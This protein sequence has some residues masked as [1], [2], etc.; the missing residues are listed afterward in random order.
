MRA[1]AMEGR[2]AEA[3]GGEQSQRDGRKYPE[4]GRPAAQRDC[5]AAEQ[6]R[7]DR[8]DAEY[9]HHP[10][11]QVCGLFPRIQV[12]HDG[13]RNDRSARHANALDEAQRHHGADRIRGCCAGAGEKKQ[14]QA[15]QQHRLAAETIGH[16]SPGKL[17]DGQ[18]QQVSG[19]GMLRGTRFG[20][21]CLCDHG[22]RRQEHVHAERRE[23]NQDAQQERRGN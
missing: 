1:G 2:S 23:C 10:R 11:Q 7:G 5:L 20:A 12:A 22:H 18:A 15:R 4:H 17:A 14:A 8:D 9:G 13:A 21:E 3:D 19:D 6:R 16:R